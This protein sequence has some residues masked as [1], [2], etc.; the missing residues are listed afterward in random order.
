[1]YE[2]SLP[3]KVQFAAQSHAPD[4]VGRTGRY[5]N[6]R[7]EQSRLK[8]GRRCCR[9]DDGYVGIPAVM[10]ERRRGRRDLQLQKGVDDAEFGEPWQ[11]QFIAKKLWHLQV[12]KR[13]L[14][15][16]AKL[17]YDQLQAMKRRV[18]VFEQ[19]QSGRGGSKCLGVALKYDHTKLRF[20]QP[21]LLANSR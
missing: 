10:A 9:D 13:A 18:D 6:L 19:E 14:H 3:I 5:E 12:D 7:E 20:Q 16:R 2:Q 21:D 17:V 11:D 15:V 1:M 4:Q 8:V